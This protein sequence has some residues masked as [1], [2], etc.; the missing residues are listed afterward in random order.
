MALRFAPAL[1]VQQMATG[2]GQLN[3]GRRIRQFVKR[4][5]TMRFAFAECGPKQGIIRCAHNR[6]LARHVEQFQE[7]SLLGAAHANA[8]Q[9]NFV[10]SFHPFRR[11]Y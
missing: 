8:A 4:Y 5:P 1:L 7:Q 6:D 10:G 3:S 9:S 11:Y 2:T